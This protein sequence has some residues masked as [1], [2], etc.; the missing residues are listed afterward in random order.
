[1]LAGGR[2]VSSQDR[3]TDPT[4]YGSRG[5][6][7]R[8]RT[9]A[10]RG[11]ADSEAVSSLLLV[12][13]D[14]GGAPNYEVMLD[15]PPTHSFRGTT[16][17]IRRTPRAAPEE[18]AIHGC[19]ELDGPRFALVCDH[20]NDEAHRSGVIDLTDQ[21]IPDLVMLLK[22]I[23]TARREDRVLRLRGQLEDGLA[24]VARALVDGVTRREPDPGSLLAL[25]F[26][27]LQTGPDW[28]PEPI[29]DISE[30]GVSV[31]TPVMSREL[32]PDGEIELWAEFDVS[33]RNIDEDH[34][35]FS[36]T[37][38]GD[39]PGGDWSS[40]GWAT[41]ADGSVLA[42]CDNEYGEPAAY[43]RIAIPDFAAPAP[44]DPRWWLALTRA[45]V[46]TTAVWMYE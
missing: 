40:E 3:D 41:W 21:G 27:L 44:A 35:W 16:F 30:D 25:P 39:R 29:P 42:C 18:G 22:A 38:S 12:A 36:C 19:V 31:N 14:S 43:S 8:V 6:R 13:A 15:W 10:R 37:G 23:A 20:R 32:N 28:D 26:S 45:I 5:A 4:G 17:M 1:M 24:L 7:S 34:G 9:A 11:N 33:L 46:L 2:I